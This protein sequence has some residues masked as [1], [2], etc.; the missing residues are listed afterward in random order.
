[1][2]LNKKEDDKTCNKLLVIRLLVIELFF[3][4]ACVIL[5]LLYL[6][7]LRFLVKKNG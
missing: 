4:E 2:V 1:M 5:E 3:A 6:K 7:E